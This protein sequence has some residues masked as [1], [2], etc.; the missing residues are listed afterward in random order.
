M[1]EN[2]KKSIIF[3][4]L[5]AIIISLGVM[6][7]F[8]TQKGS[9]SKSNVSGDPQTI[10]PQNTPDQTPP[11][12][13]VPEAKPE[14]VKPVSGKLP[15]EQALE[16]YKS[17]GYRIQLSNCSGIPGKMNIKQGTKFMVDNRDSVKH[18]V[19]L[20]SVSRS[21]ASYDY[22]V[23]VAPKYGTYHLTCDGKGSAE[24]NVYP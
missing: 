1:N 5:F 14:E 20:A 22:E 10:S 9:V 11:K 16:N 4:L 8:K 7:Y 18:I 2:S 15:Y 3:V 17:S 21:V 12:D 13:V 24:L 19:K 6:V 23:F